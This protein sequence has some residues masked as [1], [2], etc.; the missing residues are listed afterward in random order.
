MGFQTLGMLVDFQKS[1]KTVA[2]FFYFFRKSRNMPRACLKHPACLQHPACLKHP[3]C[4]QHPAC[5][6]G[7]SILHAKPFGIIKRLTDENNFSLP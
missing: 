7:D 5:L 6:K 2:L 3:A 4:Q 1:E